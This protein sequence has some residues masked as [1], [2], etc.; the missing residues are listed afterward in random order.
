MIENLHEEIQSVFLRIALIWHCHQR[1]DRSFFIRGRQVP[2]CSR[3][4]GIF[5]G[6]LAAPLFVSHIHWTLATG[7]LS[8]FFADAT[9]Q[10]CGLR[11][12]NNGLR[13]ATGIGFSVA[14]LS[15]VVGVQGWLL[16]ITQ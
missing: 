11:S 12:S 8:A 16:N 4:T 2:L 1:Q 15:L 13:F 5:V 6:V 3:C 10:Y 9:T 7:L 14:F